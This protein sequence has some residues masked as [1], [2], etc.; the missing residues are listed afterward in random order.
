MSNYTEGIRWAVGEGFFYSLNVLVQGR[1][2]DW[3]SVPCNDGLGLMRQSAVDVKR[4]LGKARVLGHWRCV[5]R[6]MNVQAREIAA[7]IDEH[8]EANGLAPF[9]GLKLKFE[10][11]A[12]MLARRN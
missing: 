6:I 5:S 4:R 3:R 2:A 10:Y 12:A 11:A 7:C 1:A 9:V 8:H